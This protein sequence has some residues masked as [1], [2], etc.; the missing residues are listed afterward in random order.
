VFAV[1]DLCQAV[2]LNRTSYY[3]LLERS[4]GTVSAATAAAA[5]AVERVFWQ[6]ARRYGAR[7]IHAELAAGGIGIGRHR[8]RAIMRQQGLQAIAPKSFVPRTTDSRHSLGYSPN[9]LLEMKLPPELPR[10]AQH[11]TAD[12]YQPMWG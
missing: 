1:R 12:R 11:P 4:G 2:N 9:L 7:R 5:A 8:I 10:V 3:R 6:H